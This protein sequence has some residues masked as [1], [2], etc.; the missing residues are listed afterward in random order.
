VHKGAARQGRSLLNFCGTYDGKV[1]PGSRLLRAV[2][3]GLL[4]LAAITACNSPSLTQGPKLATDQTLHVLL[5]DQPG[6]LDPGQ[7]Q[8][9]YETAVLRAISESL[10]KPT[11]DLSGVVPAAASSYDVVAGGT[12]YV[13]H[14][15]AGAAYSDGTAVKAQDF[16]YAWQRLIDPRLAAPEATFFSDA[17]LNGDKVSNLDPQRDAANIDAALNTLGLKALDDNTFQVTLAQPDPAFLWLAAMPAA[18]P[19][20]QDIVKKNGDKWAASPQTL[21][22][23]GPFKVSEM[24]AKDHITVVPNPHYWGARPT[25]TAIIF[26]VVND[27]AAALTK[28]KAGQLDEISV[29]PA[30]AAV[31]AGDSSLKQDLVKTPDLTVFWITFRLDAS[32]TN[33]AK[34]RLALAQAI[35]RDAFVAQIFQGQGSPATS[36]IPKGMHGYSS[37]LSAQNFDV[38]QAR[39]SLAA[40]GFSAAQLSSLTFSYDQTSDFGKATANFIHDQL[41]ANLGINITLQGLDANTY[42]SNLSTGN[43][44]IAG[45]M[46]WSADYPDPADWYD[47]FLTTSSNNTA[48]YQ[49]QQYDSF[50]RVARTDTQADRRDQEYQ[51]AQQMLVGDAPAAFLAQSVSWHL[52]RTYVRGVVTSP[53]DEWPGALSPTLISI[54]PH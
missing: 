21:I 12:V 45:P 54:A 39:A 26:Q 38:A 7:T 2:A 50:V 27:G 8:Y 14:L 32:P 42:S 6:T 47:F 29:Q 1:I 16:V 41:K 22:T 28:F 9:P 40:S 11:A 15:R 52:V 24:V 43:F 5:E 49:N 30:Q 36:F 23:N 37:S 33:N 4:V 19:V 20:R 3:L 35:D 31:V 18:A 51:Q 10:V 34:L 48:F 13:F 53:V 44:Q 17:V 25:L 46:G